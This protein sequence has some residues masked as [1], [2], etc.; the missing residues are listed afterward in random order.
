[1]KDAVKNTLKDNV[2]YVKLQVALAVTYARNALEELED[3]PW[4][5]RR[6]VLAAGLA[7]L[8]TKVLT[9]KF[10]L[11]V[12]LG[13]EALIAGLSAGFIGWLIPER[14]ES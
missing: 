6:K 10:G 5:P 9:V 12:D 13:Y 11:D 3:K 4:F 1:M 2:E 14:A 7:A 8:A